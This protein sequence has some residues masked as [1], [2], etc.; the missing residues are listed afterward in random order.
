MTERWRVL[1]RTLLA[2]KKTAKAIILAV[3]CLHNLLVMNEENMPARERL[4]LPEGFDDQ[5][6]GDQVVPGCWRHELDD[7][8]PLPL[9]LVND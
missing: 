5:E 4:Y 9:E 2:S 7:N 1:R 6:E 3:V 8:V